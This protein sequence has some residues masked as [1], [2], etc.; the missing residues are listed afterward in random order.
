MRSIS[1]AEEVTSNVLTGAW[2]NWWLVMAAV[3]GNLVAVPLRFMDSL[4][5]EWPM[6]WFVLMMGNLVELILM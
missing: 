3:V 2:Y 6:S 4:P 1:K 5:F